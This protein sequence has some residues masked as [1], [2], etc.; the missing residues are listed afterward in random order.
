[1]SD[2]K[3]SAGHVFVVR[4]KLEI[5][6][7]DAVIIPTDT[8]CT[9]EPAWDKA[10]GNSPKPASIEGHARAEHTAIERSVWFVDVTDR[11][12]PSLD[13]MQ[14]NLSD[15]LSKIASEL[16]D[17]LV[18]DR[19]RPLVAL[20]ML[21]VGGGGLREQVGDVINSLLQT[22]Q[23]AA[24]NIDI[25]LVAFRESDYAAVQ[26]ARRGLHECT[27]LAHSE[28][29]KDLAQLA[30]KDG[31]SLLIGAGVSM[32][33]GLP[34]WTG[35]LQECL[36]NDKQDVVGKDAFKNLGALDQAEYIGRTIGGLGQLKAKIA[37]RVKIAAR[38]ALGHL[39][40]ASLG[41]HAVATTNYDK[42]YED[43]VESQQGATVPK[44]IPY[45]RPAK[46]EPWL[47]KLHGDARYPDDIV[48][49]RSD[50]VGYDARSGPAGALFQSM[51]MTT[52][53][54]A[55]G[56]SFAD[57][58]ILRL[59]HEVT[60]YLHHH[61]RAQSEPAETKKPLHL[62]T[63]LSLGGSEFR[64]EI[65]N[66]ELNWIAIGEPVDDDTSDEAR[67]AAG[68]AQA[69]DLE[70]FLD[71]IALHACSSSSYLLDDKYAALVDDSHAVDASKLAAKAVPA[72][73]ESM[74][75][76]KPLR[77]TF[78]AHGF[79]RDRESQSGIK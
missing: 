42:L 74:D 48:I 78:A 28:E 23:D 29:A 70:I 79:R 54:L 63:V 62:G 5:V 27:S 59:T 76:W 19:A 43:A 34:S 49:A 21:G 75:Q 46:G 1:M 40:L 16:T 33:A 24:T 72:K 39:L 69:R 64:S 17:S 13:A 20:P 37:D 61:S 45:E 58:N 8:A 38:P 2:A 68:K 14:R 55:V 67:S 60:G 10:R 4:G 31:L 32:G 73:P 3:K 30:R 36:P 22:L 65:W 15:A 51:L 52:H 26:W 77:D 41:C 18:S 53:L 57:D 47:L 35:L 12:R 66:P 50:F 71:H 9:V 7:C 44:V 11:N 56:V 6:H 25:A